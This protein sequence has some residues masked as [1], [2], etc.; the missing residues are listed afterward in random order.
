MDEIRVCIGEGTAFRSDLQGG[1][2]NVCVSQ[3]M[4]YDKLEQCI[5]TF[6]K[7]NLRRS[8]YGFVL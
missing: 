1:P 8:D 4:D 7:K 3:L 2:H 5:S 6:C